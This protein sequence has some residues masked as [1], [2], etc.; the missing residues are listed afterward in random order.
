MADAGGHGDS[1]TDR[2]RAAVA[3]GDVDQLDI[4]IA[5][6]R[7]AATV[8]PNLA[9]ALLSR[10]DLTGDPE[11][12]D[13]AVAQLRLIVE[14]LPDNPVRASNLG[15]ALIRSFELTDDIPTLLE[16]LAILRRALALEQQ[17]GSVSP[18]LLANFGLASVRLAERT[19][20][21][22][23]VQQALDHY[24]AGIAAIGEGPQR[25]AMFA[26]LGAA[27]LLRY[28]LQ[29]S[30]ADLAMAQ[31]AYRTAVQNVP[32][33]HPYARACIGGLGNA[34][35][36]AAV[37]QGNRA[38]SVD[39]IRTLRTAL[40]GLAD[41]DP[42]G[43]LL[44]NQLAS[45]LSRNYELTGDSEALADAIS[46]LRFAMNRIAPGHPDRL[47]YQTNL[48]RSLQDRFE[49]TEAVD[50]LRAAY[51][52]AAE[53]VAAT[54]ADHPSRPGR[55]ADMANVLHLLGAHEHDHTHI[56]ESMNQLR[57]IVEQTEAANL[58]ARVPRANLAAVLLT[59]LQISWNEQRYTDAVRTIA[60][61]IDEEDSGNAMRANLLSSL[62]GLHE[63]CFRADG[64]KG[65]YSAAVHAFTEA[66]AAPAAPSRMRAQAATRLGHLHAA[67]GDHRAAVHAFRT[68][69][70]L[71]DL[72]AWR[73][74][75]RDDQERTLVE[76]R[77]L[78][79][80][81]AASALEFGDPDH[82]IAL[83]EQGRGV[84]LDQVMERRDLQPFDAQTSELAIEL[85]DV[86]D[87][88]ESG[89]RASAADSRADGPSLL[90]RQ[91]L[92]I[93]REQLLTEI[94]TAEPYADF[95]APPNMA[96]LRNA[97]G[98]GAVITV[99]LAET[100]CDALITTPD[101]TAV[102]PLPDLTVVDSGEHAVAFLNAANTLS[103]D[104]NNVLRSTLSWLWD[105]AVGPI[106]AAMGE[107][108]AQGALSR[109]WWV[110]T[111]TLTLLPIHAA[112]HHRPRDGDTRSALHRVVS[113]YTPTL[114]SLARISQ[115]PP[116]LTKT[117]VI[118]ATSGAE[119]LTEIGRE[120][121]VVKANREGQVTTL[122]GAQAT[123]AAVLAELPE[124][125]W[126]HIAGHAVS[127]Y[128]RPSESHVCLHN[129]TFQVREI[130]TLTPAVRELAY[131]SACETATGG[132]RLPDEAIH[133]ASAFQLAGFRN[134]IGTL[135]RVPDRAA[136]DTATTIYPLLRRSSP[137]VA[138]N[139]ASRQIREKYLA[140][141]YE[142][143]AFIHLGADSPTPAGRP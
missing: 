66:L 67:A 143:A 74:L 36:T 100:R 134:T 54:P 40:D 26:N 81:A 123:R 63:L 128:R 58:D 131:L 17:T 120:T 23:P 110:P 18:S 107:S 39:A 87:A 15:M 79:A 84:L 35:A 30:A 103:W 41:T 22:K 86:F 140:N 73:G 27:H 3:V 29:R 25:A 126:V 89:S 83:L 8:S 33:S 48:S 124:A 115:A 118:G 42:D 13:S 77:G 62:G 20:D 129:S 109:V 85:R 24:H 108:A 82:A 34:L 94:R 53:V 44:L 43:P 57:A 102:V 95:L 96:R 37:A 6:L 31:D 70:E 139:R 105:V 45:A 72:I 64:R 7:A 136:G 117:L 114:R 68:A 75:T 61:G 138:V 97:T 1:L 55:W 99:N 4:L 69:L 112:G 11:S 141:P 49:I 121:A 137:A 116:E 113:S 76:F 135:W 106:L 132:L 133:I 60:R 104:T 119:S 127:N 52:L 9:A 19:S 10:Y 16:A 56:D 50:D 47:S 28:T 59:S 51:D 80:A 93:R 32:N 92:A 142:W 12:L 125:S 5:Q 111:G 14:H 21:P 65:A 88:M 38:I 130:G 46:A 91:H 122:I 101:G 2:V 78:A 90:D 98:A 71:L